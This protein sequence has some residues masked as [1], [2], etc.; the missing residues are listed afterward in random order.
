MRFVIVA[1]LYAFHLLVCSVNGA[2]V[3][4][5]AA[6]H[7][8]SAGCSV[9]ASFAGPTVPGDSVFGEERA[10]GGFSTFRSTRPECVSTALNPSQSSGRFSQPHL[11]PDSWFVSPMVL[12]P[13]LQPFPTLHPP[14]LSPGMYVSAFR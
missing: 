5:S 10:H 13:F 6:A 4:G 8:H 14:F 2:H 9:L 1:G 7:G 3:V 12:L 11:V